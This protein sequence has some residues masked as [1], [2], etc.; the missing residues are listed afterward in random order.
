MRRSFWQCSDPQFISCYWQ[1]SWTVA[2]KN[3]IPDLQPGPLLS[4]LISGIFATWQERLQ[5]YCDLQWNCIRKR[6]QFC[7][8]EI[9][10]P[11]R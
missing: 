10:W 7:W 2:D 11:H 6:P 5:K 3:V 8:S 1:I 9:W 4:D